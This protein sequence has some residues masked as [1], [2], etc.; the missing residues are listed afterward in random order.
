MTKGS[1]LRAT[2][3]KRVIFQDPSS[4]KRALSIL[5]PFLK[6]GRQVIKV[7][8]V[9]MRGRGSS[10]SRE[11]SIAPK[12]KGITCLERAIHLKM[13]IRK[14]KKVKILIKWSIVP[15]QDQNILM[16]VKE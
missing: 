7:F 2:K 8:I 16:R 5:R 1:L 4:R 6:F 10:S 14:K 15:I 3:W 9:W 12:I 11:V 13:G